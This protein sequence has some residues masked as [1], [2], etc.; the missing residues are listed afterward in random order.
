[1]CEDL[2]LLNTYLGQARCTHELRDALYTFNPSTISESDNGIVNDLLECID[3]V[4]KMV[5]KQRIY[6]LCSMLKLII[7]LC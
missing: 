2:Q 6:L 1:M 5:H 7:G 3:N 4:H